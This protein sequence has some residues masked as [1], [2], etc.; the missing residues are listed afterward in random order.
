MSQQQGPVLEAKYPPQVSFFAKST[1]WSAPRLRFLFQRVTVPRSALWGV[2]TFGAGDAK[3]CPRSIG[4]NYGLLAILL[5]VSDIC[6]LAQ[7]EI[8]I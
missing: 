6:L 4:E 2:E 8:R 5:V 3:T 1:D 7:L